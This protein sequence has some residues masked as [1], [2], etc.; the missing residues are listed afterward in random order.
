MCQA[1]FAKNYERAQSMM[2]A[3]PQSK[4]QQIETSIDFTASSEQ[5]HALTCGP[6]S[7]N[8][9]AHV[10]ASR[11]QQLNVEATSNLTIFFIGE[12]FGHTPCS[13]V[14][15]TWLSGGHSKVVGSPKYSSA[16]RTCF[17][18]HQAVKPPLSSTLRT[19]KHYES[20]TRAVH[21]KP[22][23]MSSSGRQ[24]DTLYKC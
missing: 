2:H 15:G 1:L 5:R 10:H 14:F 21:E 7:L 17:H 4:V 8:I 20:Q 9:D 23:G 19:K 12:H 6:L 3:K 24:S 11:F 18:N 13:C 16:H 22:G